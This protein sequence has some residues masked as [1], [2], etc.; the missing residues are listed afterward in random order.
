MPTV[1]REVEL[2]RAR[3]EASELKHELNEWK[4]VCAA[5]QQELKESNRLLRQQRLPPRPRLTPMQRNMVAA[6]QKWKCIGANCPLAVVNDGLFTA[7]SGWEID[8]IGDGWAR[9]AMHS[10]STVQALCQ[11]CHARR[12]REQIMNREPDS[13]QE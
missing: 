5:L 2:L 3:L 1:T 13:M 10:L 9:T 11:H 8:H 4:A 6:R 7:E 12:T